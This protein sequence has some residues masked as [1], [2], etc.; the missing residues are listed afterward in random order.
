MDFIEVCDEAIAPISKHS[1]NVARK[2]VLIYENLSSFEKEK[3]F[4]LK[5]EK[6]SAIELICMCGLYHD[7]GKTYINDF[8]NNLLDKEKF[9]DA[10]KER[11]K[12]HTLMGAV[13]L[14]NV[15]EKYPSIDEITFGYLMQSCLFHHEKEDGKGYLH[16]CKPN[17]PFVAQIIT[18]A[19]IYSA[20][21]EHRVYEPSKDS[22]RLFQEM[23][24]QSINQTYVEAL[25]NGLN[26]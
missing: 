4:P 6:Y 20:G 1:E 13:M 15:Y 25:R 3:V 24:S 5:S 2:A 10:D 12:Q 16:L 14:K 23:Y 18:V 7:I 21:I 11:M 22:E 8:Y 17:I 19:D 9:T 26:K